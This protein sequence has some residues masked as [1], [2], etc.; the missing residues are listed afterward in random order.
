MRRQRLLF[1]SY[2]H[3]ILN[4]ASTI[5]NHRL[6]EALNKKYDLT[7]LARTHSREIQPFRVRTPDLSFIDRLIIKLVPSLLSVFSV[8]RL[9]W[10][11]KCFSVIKQSLSDFDV[12]II[13]YEPYTVRSLQMR[14]KK[15]CNVK[16][17]TVLYDPY[18][19]NIFFPQTRLGKFLRAKI[20]KSIVEMSDCVIVNSPRM[21][22]TFLNRYKNAYVEWQPFCGKDSVSDTLSVNN[23]KFTIV[24]AGNIGMKRNLDNL[25]NTI[26]I[27][28]QRLPN[29]AGKLNV[30]LYGTYCEGY[31][32]IIK[33]NNNDVVI[34]KGRV[35]SNEIDKILSQADALLLIDPMDE[36]NY[37][38]PSKLCEY[39][40]Y[41]KLIIGFAGKG[42]PSYIALKETNN[43]VHS[44]GEDSL[45]AEDII[46]IIEN[47]ANATTPIE[48]CEQFIPDNVVKIMTTTISKL[49]CSNKGGHFSNNDRN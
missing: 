33:D 35:S 37:S 49:K 22:N 9:V 6:I 10:A 14:I 42:T 2:G 30:L 45:M 13:P 40:Q 11:R 34:F 41:R 17:V 25:N 3:E 19:D 23:E 24:H 39:F 44:Y 48:Y 26:T 27:L 15:T 16:I 5:Q 28:K 43:I 18:F 20:E 21:Y 36:N 46:K 29:L 38:Y 1:V 12:V 7:I 4:L 8:D 31:D 47:D 32:K